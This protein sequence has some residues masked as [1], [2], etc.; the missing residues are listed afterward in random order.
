MDLQTLKSLGLDIESLG[1]R[2]VDQCVEALLR[3]TGFDPETEEETRYESRFK[4]EIEARIQKAVD[5]KIA[6][7]AEEHLLPRVGEMIEAANLRQ[8]NNYGE[9]K[10]EP[11]TFIE[12]IA[13]RAEAYMSEPVDCQGK[14]K[15]EGGYGWKSEGPR[16]TVLM[17]LHI[18]DTLD[19]EA[20]AAVCD[21]N[22]VIAKNIEQAAKDAINSAAASLK[23]SVST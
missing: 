12:Y 7:L 22:K 3:S 14:T 17:K 11:M 21:V 9:P 4:R 10:G 18:K 2:I 13:A 19:K 6:A 23:V 16:L 5:S 20:K 8:T 1:D 15:Q